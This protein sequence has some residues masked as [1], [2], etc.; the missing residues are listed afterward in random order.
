MGRIESLLHLVICM[1][2]GLV[3]GCSNR[4]VVMY[5]DWPQGL[6]RGSVTAIRFLGLP[7]EVALPTLEQAQSDHPFVYRLPA[8]HPLP[9]DLQVQVDVQMKSGCNLGRGTAHVTVPPDKR[10]PTTIHL[11]IEAF[12]RPRC[13]LTVAVTGS[14]KVTSSGGEIDCPAKSCSYEPL[15]GD[16]IGLSAY[17]QP[18][19]RAYVFAGPVPSCQ[20]TTSCSFKMTGEATVAVRF[21]PSTCAKAGWCKSPNV[22]SSAVAKTLSGVWGWNP[23]EVFIVGDGTALRLTPNGL[24]TALV[25]PSLPFLFGVA[26][27]SSEVWAVGASGSLWNLSASAITEAKESRTLS[28]GSLTAIASDSLG[29]AWAVGL[30]DA[31]LVRR[32]GAWQL[33]PGTSGL[34]KQSLNAVFVQSPTNVWAVGESGSVLHYDGTAWKVDPSS[35][36]K[37]L[38]DIQGVWGS[39]PNDIWAVGVGNTLI[40]YDGTGWTAWLQGGLPPATGTLYGLSGSGP[41]DVWAVGDQGAIWHFDGARWDKRTESGVLTTSVLFGVYAGS[42]WEAWAVGDKGTLLVYQP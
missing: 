14:G 29:N 3:A 1:L 16:T 2:L 21:L 28:S 4:D 31:L 5:L 38:P 15:L 12:P 24:P 40:H 22:P 9:A 19:L 8:E 32:S 35:I 11:P 34:P 42:P 13:P 27:T 23:S 25:S 37:S 39:G 26:G 36:L 6:D 41:S 33:S 17:P 20:G 7:S 18:G 30:Q 10:G